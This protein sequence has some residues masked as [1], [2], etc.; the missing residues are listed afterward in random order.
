M[1]CGGKEGEEILGIFSSA[2]IVPGLQF[3]NKDKC[4]ENSDYNRMTK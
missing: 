3:R 2:E 4:D 1:V